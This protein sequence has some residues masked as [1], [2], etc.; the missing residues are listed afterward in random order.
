MKDYDAIVEWIKAKPKSVQSWSH[1]V[2][3]A[4]L[5]L[6]IAQ[7]AVNSFQHY[8]EAAKILQPKEVITWIEK[9]IRK[10]RKFYRIQ[11]VQQFPAIVTMYVTFRMVSS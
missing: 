4:A 3:P 8:S 6:L 5:A 7:P 11:Q 1:A 2:A 10:A 9:N